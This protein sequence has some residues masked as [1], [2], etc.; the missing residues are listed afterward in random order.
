M[1]AG[2]AGL[3]LVGALF[4]PLPWVIGLQIA[5][6]ALW[7]WARIAFGRRS[8]HPGPEPTP[9]GIVTRGPYRHVRHPIYT[10]VSVLAWPAALADGSPAAIALAALVT[11]AAVTRMLC[12]ERLLQRMYP[13]YAAY[14]RT[15][16]RMI[17]FVF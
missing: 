9:G 6:A 15:T 11:G 1:L 4:S 5:A 3:Y 2:Y 8:F 16:R 10:A 12:E 14:A 13:D 17:P 7:L